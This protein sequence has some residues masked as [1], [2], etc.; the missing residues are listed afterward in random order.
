M[1]FGV[2][3]RDWALDHKADT[4]TPQLTQSMDSLSSLKNV[5][6]TIAEHHLFLVRFG[7]GLVQEVQ[8]ALV[9]LEISLRPQLRFFPGRFRASIRLDFLDGFSGPWSFWMGVFI[10][11]SSP[12]PGFDFNFRL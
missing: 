11:V 9:V 4:S 2:Q 7:V 3:S 6:A 5:L 1:S 12:R 8:H 10:V